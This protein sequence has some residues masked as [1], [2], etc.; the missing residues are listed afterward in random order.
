MKS[1]TTKPSKKAVDAIISARCIKRLA[2]ALRNVNKHSVTT[3]ELDQ[4]AALITE[5]AK[6]L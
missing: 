6:Q 5:K 2:I 3:D 1:Q 4:M